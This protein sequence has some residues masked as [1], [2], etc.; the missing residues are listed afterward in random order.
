MMNQFNQQQQKD[1]TPD[2]DKIVTPDSLKKLLES[3]TEEEKKE[4]S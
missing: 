2:I 1:R 4:M 3:Q